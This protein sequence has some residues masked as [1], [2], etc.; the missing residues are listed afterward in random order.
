MHANQFWWAWPF[1]FQSYGSI[2]FSFKEAK[3]S[4]RTMIESAQKIHAKWV[5]KISFNFNFS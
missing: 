5:A 2:L 3:I 4:L 1:W